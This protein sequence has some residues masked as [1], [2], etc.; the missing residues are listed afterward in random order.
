MFLGLIGGIGWFCRNSSF[1]SVSISH[2]MESENGVS[3]EDESCVIVKNYVEESVGNSEVPTMNG[4][5]E[6]F[7]SSEVVVK[8]STTVATSKN[9][10]S[11]KVLHKEFPHLS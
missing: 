8:A 4:I 9:S 5:S 3:L 6:G 7:N 1:L 2:T 11:I 10:K